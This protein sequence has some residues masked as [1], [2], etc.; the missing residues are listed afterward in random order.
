MKRSIL[1][2]AVLT[3]SVLQVSSQPA[4]KPSF[5]GTWELEATGYSEI[6]TYEHDAMRLHLIQHIDDSLGK[7]TIDATAPIDGVPHHLTIEGDDFILMAQWFGD[8]LI[9]ETRRERSNGIFRNRRIMTLVG[10]DQIRALRTR[11]LPGPEQSWDET[12]Y[13]LK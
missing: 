4:E 10:H 7:R 8:S 13:R 9:F 1:L 12:W 2:L 11:F 5:N 3:A 6:Y